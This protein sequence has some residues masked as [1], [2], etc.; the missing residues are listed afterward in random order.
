MRASFK[1]R[2]VLAR[3]SPFTVGYRGMGSRSGV[4]GTVIANTSDDDVTL[5]SADDTTL[6]F[7][8]GRAATQSAPSGGHGITIAG[9]AGLV[10]GATYTVDSGS[11][12]V[13]T[14]PLGTG[15]ELTIGAG[16]AIPPPGDTLSGDSAKLVLT[17]DASDGGSALCDRRD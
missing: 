13:G 9:T 4:R 8:A 7:G 2:F 15:A 1:T 10:S 5:M 16:V 6:K 3:P 11:S 12:N 14:L 17:G